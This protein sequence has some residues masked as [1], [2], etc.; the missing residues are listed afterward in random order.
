LSKLLGSGSW[1][2][3]SCG[4]SFRT[5]DLLCGPARLKKKGVSTFLFPKTYTKEQSPVDVPCLL[6][7]RHFVSVFIFIS[8]YNT[9]S[10]TPLEQESS[11][12]EYPTIYVA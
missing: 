2:F 6:Q 10:W 5:S 12:Y 7:Q 1:T 8:Y 4:F 11:F 9:M 3:D